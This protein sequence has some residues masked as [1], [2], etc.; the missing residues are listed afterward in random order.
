MKLRTRK[1]RLSR[2]RR[3]DR[4]QYV[5]AAGCVVCVVRSH[6]TPSELRDWRYEGSNVP[7]IH[8]ALATLAADLG[9][10]PGDTAEWSTYDASN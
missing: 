10:H 2:S 1:K 5:H 6:L 3:E 8:H 7:W 4:R 9:H